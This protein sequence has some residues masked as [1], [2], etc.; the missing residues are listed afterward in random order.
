MSNRAPFHQEWQNRRIPKIEADGITTMPI[1]L[2]QGL[3]AIV[4]AEDFAALNAFKWYA[5][6]AHG[7]SCGARNLTLP[8]G[9]Q[10]NEKMQRTVMDRKLGRPLS[11]DEKVVHVNGDRLDNRRENLELKVAPRK[12]QEGKT[13]SES[14]FEEKLKR[15]KNRGSKLP[16][17]RDA[18]ACGYGRLIGERNDEKFAS[19]LERV[20]SQSAARMAQIYSLPDP[21]S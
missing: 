8:D 18:L 2:T 7:I 9:G 16:L 3:S 6:T 20:K 1:P 13:M 17:R 4:D 14:E 5:Q 12:K 19:A 21:N 11:D 10:T 15:W